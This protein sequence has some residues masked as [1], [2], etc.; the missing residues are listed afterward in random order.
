M[1]EGSTVEGHFYRHK[2]DEFA[3][4]LQG[5][6]E[7]EIE[8]KKHLL[9]QGDSFYIE[10]TVPSQ[11]ANAGKGEAVILWVLSPPRGGW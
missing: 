10:S 7:V 2:G 3:Y 9:R 4:I 5:E 1:K 8:G 6:L 11:W